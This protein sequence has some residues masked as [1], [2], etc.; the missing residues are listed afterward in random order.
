MQSRKRDGWLVSSEP[1]HMMAY[2]IISLCRVHCPG[3]MHALNMWLNE[4]LKQGLYKPVVAGGAI[5]DHIIS[6]T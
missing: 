3:L 2:L 5:G 6:Y 1:E 4:L